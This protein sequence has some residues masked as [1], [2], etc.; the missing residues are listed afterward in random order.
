MQLNEL[1]L[2]ELS[3][4]LREEPGKIEELVDALYGEIEKKEDSIGAYLQLPDRED[5]INRARERSDSPL[6]GIPAA[7]KDNIQTVGMKTTCG[8]K[9]LADYDSV[10]DATVVKKL[11]EKG[12]PVLGKTYMDE[13][14]MGSSTENS[15][16]QITKNPLDLDRV[17]GGSS[18]GS[19][20][21]VASDEAIYALGSDTGGSIRQ[22]AAFCGVV[23]LKPTYGLVSRYGL[24]AFASSLDQIG[25]IT[26]DVRDAAIVLNY[27]TGNDELDSTS[28]T[29]REE[30]FEEGLEEGIKGATVG[31]PEEYFDERLDESIHDLADRWKKT[32]EDLGAEI[33]D[34]SLPH[35]E[36]A[37]ATYYLIAC[38][39]ASANLA[40]F[41]G[42][43]YTAR[44]ESKKIDDLFA[45]SREEGLGPEVK[46]RIMLGTYAL[47]TGY[48]DQF[49]KKA[50]KVR[51]L[52]KKDFDRAW[53]KV[54]LVATPTT[55]APA[56]KLGEK[57]EDP[58]EMYLSDIFTETANLA[59][60]P[61]ISIPAGEVRDL[62]VGL[63]L[64]TEGMGEKK[65]LKAAYAVE[66]SF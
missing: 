4:K 11:K 64:M 55:P 53:E 38:S 5:L 9:I 54:D 66:K 12:S 31:F 24:T 3:P 2:H 46:R 36:Y 19:A 39:E 1:T 17:P 22:P 6:A 21:A 50:Q 25:P 48:Y 57:I 59:G 32:F 28:T 43:R 14:A 40:R 7:I 61:A 58:L 23:G 65:L 56:F 10:Y 29:S 16:F 15:A 49:Y 52:I 8:S 42:V 63:Q 18:G 33:V 35:T 20:A 27:I 13:F 51:N 45:N 41:D 60:I 62:P 26:K 34:I 44:A 37:T 47:S 30:D